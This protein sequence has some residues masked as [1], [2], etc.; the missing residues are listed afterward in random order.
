VS[1]AKAILWLSTLALVAQLAL[2]GVAAAGYFD[3]PR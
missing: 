2:A 3:G 1:R